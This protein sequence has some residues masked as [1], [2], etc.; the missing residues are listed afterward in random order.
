MFGVEMITRLANRIYITGY[1]AEKLR[2]SKCFA[3]P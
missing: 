3:I 1:R 2:E